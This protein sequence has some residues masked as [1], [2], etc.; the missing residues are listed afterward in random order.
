MKIAFLAGLFC[1]A[2]PVTAAI[3]AIYSFDSQNGSDSAGGNTATPNANVS[4]STNTPFGPAQGYAFNVSNGAKLTA[5]HGTGSTF[6]SI[7][8]NLSVSFWIKADTTN[9]TDWSRIIRKGSGGANSWIIGR[10]MGTADTNIRVDSGATNIE[11]YNQNLAYSS[12]G[13]TILNDQWH[14]VTYVLEYTSG[15]HGTVRE[16]VDGTLL[17]PNGGTTF[18]LGGGL[19]NT[20]A[21]EIGVS[22]GSWTGLMDDVGI[23]NNA[24][25]AAEVRSIYTLGTNGL[26]AYDL[27]LV[28]QLHSLYAQGSAGGSLELNGY[29][30][31]YSDELGGSG[32]NPGD[33]YYNSSLN[34]W[35]LQMSSTTGL[36]AAPE[37]GRTLLVALSLTLLIFTRRRPGRLC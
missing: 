21:L 26:F 9:N 19:G 2:S 29:D 11:G 3:V 36:T 10:Y 30:W 25:T 18:I 12:S 34:Q 14:L 5:V 28:T 33:L 17:T 4:Y 1:L 37:P 7:G 32:R 22:T 8:N 31:Q 23:W 24:L 20:H 13:G 6:G 15:T 35:V 27:D 16:Y